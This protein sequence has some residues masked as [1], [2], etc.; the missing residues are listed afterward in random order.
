LAANAERNP[1]SADGLLR[2]EVDR[3]AAA[4]VAAAAPVRI[5]IAAS[6]ADRDAVYRLRY[7]HVIQADWATPEELP[8][9]REHVAV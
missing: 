4:A 2:T 6:P 3:L 5:A 9:E 8:D 7:Q 1:A